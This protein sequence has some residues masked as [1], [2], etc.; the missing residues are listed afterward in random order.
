MF[1][2]VLKSE[3]YCHMLLTCDK[4]IY[5]VAK[6]PILRNHGY[7]K[8]LLQEKLLKDSK[9]TLYTLPWFGWLGCCTH[10]YLSGM[11]SAC[12]SQGMK[13]A[14]T[15]C[16]PPPHLFNHGCPKG[17]VKTA[18]RQVSRR[19]SKCSNTMASRTCTLPTNPLAFTAR[20][21]AELGCQSFP[22]TREILTLN[23]LLL[24]PESGKETH[25]RQS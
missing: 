6:L 20:T 23:P 1:L 12:N 17:I 3:S 22:G 4:V 19:S 2:K 15:L 21:R 14:R 11:A 13:N 5:A 7:P 10:R 16:G 8:M 9:R 18:I 24:V 25:Q